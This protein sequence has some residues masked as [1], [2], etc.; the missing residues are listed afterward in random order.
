MTATRKPDGRRGRRRWTPEEDAL[1]IEAATGN[2]VLGLTQTALGDIPAARDA[3]DRQPITDERGY[4]RRLEA[5][6]RMTGRTYDAVKKRASRLGKRSYRARAGTVRL[7]E[8]GTHLED[9]S[10]VRYIA[11][12]TMTDEEIWSRMQANERMYQ[13]FHDTE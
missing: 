6:A 12:M 11:G 4:I 1:V 2:R 9:A 8:D 3:M 10:G 5:V 7:S 13:P